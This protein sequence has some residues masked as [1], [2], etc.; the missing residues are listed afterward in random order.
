MQRELVLTLTG[1]D[2]IGIV[3]EVTRILLGRGG[4]VE[5]SRMARLGGEFAILMLVSLPADQVDALET[6]LGG[7]AAQGYKVTTSAAHP[8]EARPG[9]VPFRIEVEG[10]DHEGIIQEVARYLAGRGIHIETVDSET[11]AAPVSGSPLFTMTAEVAVPPDL[12]AQGWQSGLDE[13]SGRMNLE[14]RVSE[15]AD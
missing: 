6:D 2:R 13:I 5:T 15:I 14:I 1:P 4:N 10:A 7:L 9:W 12:A 3:E 11:T 8:A